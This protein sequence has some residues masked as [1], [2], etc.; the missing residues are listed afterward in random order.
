MKSSK[1]LLGMPAIQKLGLIR[2]I[3]GA[4]P[5]FAIRTVPSGKQNEKENRDQLRPNFVSKED[6]QVRYPQFF[7]GLGGL[8]GE[9][10][11]ELRDNAKPFRQTVS[12]RVPVLLLKKIEAEL[13]K[14]VVNNVIVPVD[15][16]TD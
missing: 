5:I 4:F 14:M 1:L 6:V 3:P 12:R 2:D 13:N 15:T 8:Q 9:Q 16:P 10:H 7:R 11:I